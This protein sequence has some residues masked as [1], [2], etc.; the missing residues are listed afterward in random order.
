MQEGTADSV[1]IFSILGTFACSVG[2]VQSLEN[3]HGEIFLNGNTSCG[4]YN[5]YNRFS[6]MY[7]CKLGSIFSDV[8]LLQL[9]YQNQVPRNL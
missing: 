2:Q 5:Y 1:I 8:P 4:I 9:Y 7:V 6:C 3:D